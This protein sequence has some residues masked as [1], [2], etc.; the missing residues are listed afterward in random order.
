MSILPSTDWSLY[1]CTLLMDW[2]VTQLAIEVATIPQILC[3][4]WI[5][6]TSRLLQKTSHRN[7][8]WNLTLPVL[9]NNFPQSW[10]GSFENQT[11]EL[12]MGSMFVLSKNNWAAWLSIL[13]RKCTVTATFNGFS[14]QLSSVFHASLLSCVLSLMLTFHSQL[15]LSCF[16][17]LSLVLPFS[18]LFYYQ[19]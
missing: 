19:F 17:S 5:S 7:M 1:K 12:F 14:S 6:V 15:C 9:H 8:K 18:A 3:W 2:S 10:L 16:L 4:L 13:V 11:I